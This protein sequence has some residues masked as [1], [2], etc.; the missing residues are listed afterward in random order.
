M[1]DEQW[2]PWEYVPT[3]YIKRDKD[4]ILEYHNRREEKEINKRDPKREE[5]VNAINT[6]KG[7]IDEWDIKPDEL[8]DGSW[9]DESYIIYDEDYY[10]TD[11]SER[12]LANSIKIH[13]ALDIDYKCK[14][15]LVRAT[16]CKVS[17][18]D[19]LER[20]K[21]CD[22]VSQLLNSYLADDVRD[23]YIENDSSVRLTFE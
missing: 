8:F 7:L 4:K 1:T 20:S 12:G 2:D 23:Y 3:S 5:R 22:G 13:D 17:N 9:G 21:E 11:W 19:R 14:V 16:C 10:G 18:A 15:C 6:V